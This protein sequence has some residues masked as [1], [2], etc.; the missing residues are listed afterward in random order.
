MWEGRDKVW[1]WAGDN[2]SVEI[3]TLIPTMGHMIF[4]FVLSNVE[5]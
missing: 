1:E 2:I 5:K 3:K 4:L